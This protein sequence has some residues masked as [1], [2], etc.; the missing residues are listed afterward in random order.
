M[1]RILANV[2]SFRRFIPLAGLLVWIQLC[3][4]GVLYREIWLVTCREHAEDSDN[5]G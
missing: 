5:P 4:H 2:H 1:D 3:F